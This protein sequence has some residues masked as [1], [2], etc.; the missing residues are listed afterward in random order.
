MSL[1][2]QERIRWCNEISKINRKLSNEPE[3]KMLIP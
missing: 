2:H 1:S 3:Q